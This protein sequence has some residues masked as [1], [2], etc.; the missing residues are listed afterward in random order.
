LQ[1]DFS[2]GEM[3]L[4]KNVYLY[5]AAPAPPCSLRSQI[6]ANIFTGQAENMAARNTAA[7][8]PNKFSNR[9]YFV[10]AYL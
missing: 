6:K 7:I 10:D 8:L 2:K 4:R 9:P 3:L 5:G 1:G